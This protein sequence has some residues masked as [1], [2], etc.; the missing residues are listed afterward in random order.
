MIQFNLL[1]DV[2][3][4][5]LKAKRLRQLLAFISIATAGAFFVIAVLT[6]LA[7]NVIQK[8]QLNSLGAELRKTA[9]IVQQ[10][11][12][13]DRIITVQNQLRSLQ[14]IDKKK[15]AAGRLF[16]YLSQITPSN[17]SISASNVDFTALTLS[18]S[19]TAKDFLGVNTFVDTLKYTGFKTEATGTALKP[20]FSKVYLGSFTNTDKGSTFQISMTFDSALFD[21]QQKISLSVPNTITTRLDDKQASALFQAAATPTKQDNK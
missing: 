17:V 3:V 5:Y 11:P 15:P 13:V 8:N 14:E 20:A 2:K 12:D 16:T 18:L 21:N 19:G 7:V 9:A 10:T 1:P 4:Q 6:F